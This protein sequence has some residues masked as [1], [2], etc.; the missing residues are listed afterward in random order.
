MFT[1]KFLKW[2][3]HSQFHSLR[4]EIRSKNNCIIYHEISQRTALANILR[5]MYKLNVKGGISRV[6]VFEEHYLGM[7]LLMGYK[8]VMR[9]FKHDIECIRFSSHWCTFMIHA[10]D[11]SLYSHII[12]LIVKISSLY[13]ILFTIFKAMKRNIFISQEFR[14]KF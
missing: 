9:R 14:I 12:E 13:H 10:F 3:V 2:S 1:L 6:Q 5:Y 7:H 4:K 11:L 8:Y